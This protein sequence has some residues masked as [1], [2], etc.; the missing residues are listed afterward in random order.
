MLT[1]INALDPIHFTFDTS[2]A[3]YL[4]TQRERARSGSGGQRVEIRLQD[5]ADYSRLGRVDFTDNG[6][7]AQSGT[8][9]ARAVVANP[10]NFLAPGMFGNMRLTGGAPERAMLIPD[11]AVRTDQARKI[12]YV[13]VNDAI[14][15]KPVT[16]GPRIGRLRSIRSG[17]D[18]GDKV[19]IQGLQMVQPGAKVSPRLGRINPPEQATSVAAAPAQSPVSAQAT[20]ASN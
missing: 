18:A 19:V 12:V 10:D 9:R 20:L 15:V 13:V 2:E 6:I 8:I 4:K 1:T 11:A 3:L 17:L 16:V 14:E 5:E 7:S